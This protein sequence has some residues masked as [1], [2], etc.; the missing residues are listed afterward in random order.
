MKKFIPICIVVLFLCSGLA[1][2]VTSVG[3]RTVEKAS[4]RF[5]QPTLKT[6]NN[7]VSVGLAEANSYLMVQGKPM[8]PSYVQTFYYPFGTTISGVSVTPSQVH[9]QSVSKDVEPTPRMVSMDQQAKTSVVDSVSYGAETYPSAWFTYDVGCG[10]H[11]GV[12]SIIVSV[13]VFP[14]K[15]HPADKT[16]QYADEASIVVDYESSPT[17]AFAPLTSYQFVV[18]GPSEY[19]SQVSPLI[20]HKISRGITSTFV[21]LTDIYNSVY[22]PV[23]G[24]DNQEK[25]KYFI[26]DAIESWGTTAVLL[27]GGASKVPTRDTHVYIADDPE[28]GDEVFVSDLYYADIYNKT[29][30]FSSWDTNANNLFGEFNWN[31]QTDA[32][33]LH[34]DVYLARWPAISGAQVTACVNKVVGYETTPGYQQSWFQN[35]VVIGGDSFEDT[36]GVNEGEY[37]NQKVADLMTGF[38]PNKIWASNGKLSSLVPTGVSNIKTAINTGAGFVD[39]NGHGNT[40]VWASHPH[41]D[42]YTWIPTPTG[43][44]SSNDISTLSNGNKL[45]IIT[46]DAC[47]TAKFAEDTNSYNWAFMYNTNGGAIATFGC[48]GLGYSYTGSSVTQGLVG[49]L[50]LDTYK[51]YKTDH[52]I[53]FGEMWATA[54]NRYIKTSMNDGDYKSVEEWNA[55]GDPTLAIAELS[56]PP[57]KPAAPS[58]PATGK[59]GTEYTYTSSTTDP[60][61]DQVSYLFDW[62]DNTSSGWVGPFASGATAS[63]VKTWTT[64]GSYS[65]KV[66]AKDTHGVVSVWSDP[67]PITMPYVFHPFLQFLEKLL[68][69][70]PNAFPLLRALLS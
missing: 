24:R 28:Y 67:L 65:V 27:V 19:S 66:V 9:I 15:Y 22:F 43:R 13:E 60:D 48:T 55:F 70:F 14:V 41:G 36:G 58:G 63:A 61:G 68:E 2:A 1:A 3:D 53:T 52:A 44:I 30:A 18:I 29:S 17:P 42:F 32:V 38:I 54:L 16:L 45:P 23:N 40:N 33:D 26:K 35:L 4:V 25:I 46:V 31:G 59:V 49:K 62:G 5:S 39:F 47:S 57:V 7:F 56:N 20:T 11:N 34:P 21:S 12:L 8:L 64:K 50:D 69:R 51:A 37:G 6:S 10:L